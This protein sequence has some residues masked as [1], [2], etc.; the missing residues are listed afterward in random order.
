MTGLVFCF[1]EIILQDFALQK[2]LTFAEKKKEYDKLLQC[3]SSLHFH[4][5]Y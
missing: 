4:K 1:L 2:F 3:V 5:Q